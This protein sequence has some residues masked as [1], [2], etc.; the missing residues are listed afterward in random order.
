M[1]VKDYG[2]ATSG[3]LDPEGRNW[4]TAVYEAGKPVLDKELNLVQDVGQEAA[5]RFRHRAVPSGWLADDFL[6]TSDPT[7]GIFTASATANELDLPQDL[8]AH[9]NG[10]YITV[11]NTNSNT[12]NALDLGASPSGAGSKRT[13]LVILEVWRRLISPSPATDGK[14]ASGRIWLNGNVKVASADDLTLNFADD[15][16]DGSVGSETTKRVQIQYRLR[17]FQGVDLFSFPAGI[18]PTLYAH[19]VPASAAAPD[20]V[21]T[22]YNYV[23]QSG[24]GD[25][26]LWRAGD[27]NPANTLGT[28]DGYMYAIPLCAVFRRNDTAFDKNTNHNGGVATPGPSDRPD[29]LFYDILDAKDIVDLRFGVSLVGWDFPEVLSKNVNFLFDN[30]VRQEILTTTIGGGVNGS[31]H[32]WA[33]EIGITNANGGDGTTTGD[34]PGAAFIGQFDAVCRRF[35]DRSIVEAVVVEYD[36]PGGTWN[37]GDVVTIDPSALPIWPYT[38]FNYTAYAPSDISFVGISGAWFAG[39]TAGQDTVEC[40][41]YVLEGLGTVPPTSMTFT[42]GSTLPG[43]LNGDEKLHLYLL[44]EYPTGVGLSKTPTADFGANSLSINNPGQLPATAPIYYEAV[45]GFSFD[46]PHREVQ[47]EYHTVTQTLAFRQQ[48]VASPPTIQMPERVL[49]ISQIR[50]NA[51]P[52]AGTITIDGS[53]YL[54]TLDPG[55]FVADD[56]V[57]VDYKGI[58]PFPQNDE[59][60]TVY[61]DAMTPQTV[62]EA[63]LGTSIDVVPRYVPPYLYSITVGSGAQGEAYPFPYQYVQLGSVYPGSGGSYTGDHELDGKGWISTATFSA[64]TG[65]LQLG[66]LVPLVPSPEALAFDRAPGDIDA[67]S[68]T[69]F[70]SVPAGYTD[71]AFGQPLTEPR[72]HKVILPILAE[73]PADSALGKAGQLVLVVLSR[74]AP[75]DAINA[76]GF[77]STLAYNSTTASVYRLKGNLLN[78]RRG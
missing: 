50:V 12:L 40:T 25:P 33:D 78:N 49:S 7:V 75:F 11:A 45:E 37:A 43:T 39:S 47:I 36:P 6:G 61:Y 68:R 66:S 23:N 41:D 71:M 13:D 27:G 69:Y 31:E 34:T 15:I 54:I 17:V 51:T 18:D 16:L 38:A 3:Y 70:K 44:V 2:A 57:E 1:A 30:V 65:F 52:Y 10:W 76:V 62:R 42:V 67:E 48:T 28:V 74:Y 24:A 72:T 35:S 77:I 9:V 5:R 22:T 56:A 58:R 14:S 53:G 60:V 59:Q 8:L 29:G 19:T 26:G 73:L 46:Y 32:L 21:A 55:A 64:G 4:E 20:G 63:L